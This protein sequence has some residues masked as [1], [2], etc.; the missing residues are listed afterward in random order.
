MGQQLRV[1]V[2]E[3][4]PIVGFDLCDTV[5]EAGYMVEGPFDE[6]SSA[7]LSFQKCKPDIAILDVQLGDGIVYPLAEQMMAENVP[8]IF[9]S[10]RLSPDEVALRFP[11]AQAL[12]KP[13]PPA[14][15][16]DSI[17]RAAA[18]A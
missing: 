4:E 13:C 12:S 9:H 15:M 1:L 8:V 2:A 18:K 17:Q 3:D 11:R 5:A 6:I 10:G 14:E 7:M 16:I